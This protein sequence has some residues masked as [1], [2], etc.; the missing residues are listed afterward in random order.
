[1]DLFDELPQSDTPLND[2][3][4]EVDNEY[5]VLHRTLLQSM[6]AIWQEKFVALLTLYQIGF[7]N[8]EQS[9]LYLVLPAKQVENE[10]YVV[11]DPVQPHNKGIAYVHPE[12]L[13]NLVDANETDEE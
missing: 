4:A 1:M 5:I 10:I 13:D 6:P 7:M 3:L 2:W 8:V 9:A 12:G 11:A